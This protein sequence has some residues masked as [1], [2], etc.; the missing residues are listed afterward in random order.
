MVNVPIGARRFN[1]AL[2]HLRRGKGRRRVNVE[3]GN[4]WEGSL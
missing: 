3:R 1:L 2:R 4:E